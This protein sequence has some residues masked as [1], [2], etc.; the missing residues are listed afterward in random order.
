[1][2]N[3]TYIINS[4]KYNNVIRRSWKCELLEIKDSLYIF[5]GVFENEVNHS[6][7][8]VIGRNTVSIEYFWLD[9]WFNIFRFENPEGELMGYYCN[10]NFP[11]TI[12]ENK[13]DFIDLDLDIFVESNFNF[14]ILDEDEFQENRLK[15]NYTEKVVKKSVE[16]IDEVVKMIGNR[17][18]PFDV[19]L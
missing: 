15:Y 16:A 7:I 2:K 17:V 13:V 12:S 1:M 9:K 5:K 10:I 19:G 11:P 18:F 14:R 3:P 4:R 6:E 8:G